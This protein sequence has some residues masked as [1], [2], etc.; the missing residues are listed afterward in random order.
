MARSR[1]RA[2]KRAFHGSQYT[3]PVSSQRV[4]RPAEQAEC[5]SSRKLAL[6]R[7]RKRELENNDEFYMLLHSSVL[8]MILQQVGRCPS[9]NSQIVFES[10]FAKRNGFCLFLSFHCQSC[11]WTDRYFSSPPANKVKIS[12]GRTVF[13][14]NMRMAF[15]FR[16]I[17]KGYRSLATLSVFM[18][19]APPITK[20]NYGKISDVMCEAYSKVAEASMRKAGVEVY[21]EVNKA[22]SS[23]DIADCD[24]S[25]DGTWQRRGYSSLNGVVTVLSSNTGKCIDAYVLSKKCK[26]CEIWSKREDHPRY[27]D[28]KTTHKCQANHEKSSGAMESVGA[29]ALFQRSIE[30]HNLRYVGYIGDGDSSSFT[31]VKNAEP[32]GPSILIEKKE[33]IGHVQ[34]RLGTRC[35]ELCRKLRGKKLSDGKVIV[36]K[37][38]LSNRA[39]NT[40]QNYYGMAIRQNTDNLYA[41][42]KAVGAV[43]YHCSDIKKESIHHHFCP[44]GICS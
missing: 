44:H 9:C 36:G 37:G 32:Y 31:E 20:N 27:L 23:G 40:M 6:S 2:K 42:R 26:G 7:K 10:D 5:S 29:L 33:C 16:E 15:A 30:K 22:S 21:S 38:R 19:M 24:V 1:A 28:W 25:V 4:P 35:R 41:M 39:I 43:L 8:Q 11:N 12:P 13:D 14:V 34:K 18:N 17:G 3:K